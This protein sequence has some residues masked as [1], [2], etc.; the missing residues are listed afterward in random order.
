MS[1]SKNL[2]ANPCGFC[3]AAP[4]GRRHTNSNV[5]KLS[6]SPCQESP[7]AGWDVGS[8]A[9]AHAAHC[10]AR[11]APPSVSIYPP[12]RAAHHCGK[13]G[14]LAR[15]AQQRVRAQ[16]AQSGSSIPVPA[17]A[18]ARRPV[19]ALWPAAAPPHPRLAPAALSKH[20]SHPR[21]KQDWERPRCTTRTLPRRR[22]RA[23]QRGRCHG[24]RARP[25]AAHRPQPP[26]H[27][28]C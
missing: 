12:A 26:P 13:S 2:S 18:V 22:G 10:G 19:N 3:C 4:L 17:S 11:P 21:A 16:N 5:T 14:V 6:L 20:H 15:R 9:R 28:P 7:A 1:A 24:A 25:S 23:H 27:A 8:A